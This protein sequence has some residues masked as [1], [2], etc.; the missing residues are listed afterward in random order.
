M[1]IQYQNH[2]HYFKGSLEATLA[3]CKK[4]ISNHNQISITPSFEQSIWNV[5]NRWASQG[6]RVLALAKG[7]QLDQL[8]FCGL[9]ALS[10][11]PRPEVEST[12][13]DLQRSGIKPVIITGDSPITAHS[14]A[15]QIGLP[16]HDVT[17]D[18]I[19]GTDLERMSDRELGEALDRVW[20]FARTTPQHK[21]RIV[22][23]FQARGDVVAM[24]GDGVNDTPALR[25]SDLGVAM[26]GPGASDVARESAQLI[27]VKDNLRGLVSGVAEG[28]GIFNNI[29]N[30]LTFQLSTSLATLMLVAL[31]TVFKLGNP[32]NAMQILYVNI[33]MDGPPAQS[34]GVEAYDPAIVTQPP[35]QRNTSL[36]TPALLTRVIVNGL[37]MGFGTFLVYLKTRDPEASIS[38]RATTMTFTALVVFDMVNALTCRSPS[39]ILGYHSLPHNWSFYASVGASLLGHVLVLYVPFLQKVFQTE[40]ISARDWL[41]LIIMSSLIII[42]D[43]IIKYRWYGLS[44]HSNTFYKPVATNDDQEELNEL[45][46]VVENKV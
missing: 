24:T 15:R 12:L 19:I 25:L 43:G 31:T 21:L 26:G 7:D 13:F 27:L 9:V 20:I 40:A 2:P 37:L 29:Q 36:L 46:I 4:Y 8:V 44:T 35:R 30:F 34:L 11:P 28:R 23:A 16:V 38:P 3:K 39:K 33:L 18:C 5:H 22:S 10:D 41:F 6:F 1:S 45:R 32:L 14:I 17:Q 42:V